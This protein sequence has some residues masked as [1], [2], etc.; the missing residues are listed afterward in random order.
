MSD[1]HNPQ[2]DPP[3]ADSLAVVVADIHASAKL[4]EGAVV[5]IR[6]NDP[7]NDAGAVKT[8]ARATLDI[9]S[10]LVVLGVA[11]VWTWQNII[12]PAFG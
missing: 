3:T 4:I 1:H 7:S 2:T 8:I 6:D 11:A 5:K 10:K 9:G 12:A